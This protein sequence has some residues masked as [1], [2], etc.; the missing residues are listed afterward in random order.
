[1]NGSDINTNI[2]TDIDTDTDRTRWGLIFEKFFVAI[3][4][5]IVRII[6]L[7]SWLYLGFFFWVPLLIRMVV[8]FTWSIVIYSFTGS[9]ITNA[10]RKLD[11]AIRF[12]A[13][14]FRKINRAVSSGP[15]SDEPAQRQGYKFLW[16]ILPDLAF[17]FVFWMIAGIVYGFIM[18]DI[19]QISTF[20]ADIADKLR[21]YFVDQTK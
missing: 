5:E 15:I 4:R 8:Y 19:S 7:G 21:E 1:M 9:E 14:G 13:E 20:M 3:V 16:G 10:Q 17:S 6:V 2:D 18:I 11:R 12:Y